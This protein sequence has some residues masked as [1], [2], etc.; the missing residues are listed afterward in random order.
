M[1]RVPD[2]FT[3]E[4]VKNVAFRDLKELL[5]LSGR[6]GA[7]AEDHKLHRFNLLVDIFTPDPKSFSS[8][9]L[10][11]SK[12]SIQPKK[13][14]QKGESSLCYVLENHRFLSKLI[15]DIGVDR[16]KHEN[17]I[18]IGEGFLEELSKLYTRS[19][20]I[21]LVIASDT[22]TVSQQEVQ[23]L[24]VLLE[25]LKIPE[26]QPNLEVKI[27]W[28][29]RASQ[30]SVFRPLLSRR[31]RSLTLDDE[32]DYVPCLDILVDLFDKP[33]FDTLVTGKD[34]VLPLLVERWTKSSK[35]QLLKF[36][37]TFTGSHF[38]END[39]LFQGFKKHNVKWSKKGFHESLNDFNIPAR[40]RRQ[41]DDDVSYHGDQVCRFIYKKH[42]R[43]L[44]DYYLCLLFVSSV[45]VIQSSTDQEETMSTSKAKQHAEKMHHHEFA[46]CS[47]SAVMFFCEM[48]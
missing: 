39:E 10:G 48:E 32:F 6:Y 8:S 7:Y 46:Q 30:Q 21:Q 25:K 3:Q 16:S 14:L 17:F 23:N 28:A 20:A 42:P 15:I 9:N 1:D 43:S 18:C 44:K 5:K 27:E 22:P 12:S 37:S 36:Y 45:S 40:I 13:K 35:K 11:V 33:D 41:I 24:H 4:V 31:M 29:D 19:R 26:S 38:Y 47:E 2:I 34:T